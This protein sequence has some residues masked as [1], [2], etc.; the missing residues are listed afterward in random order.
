M[1]RKKRMLL[2]STA[3]RNP[4]TQTIYTVCPLSLDQ[5]MKPPLPVSPLHVPDELKLLEGDVK[6]LVLELGGL[7]ILFKLFQP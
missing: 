3:N 6:V 7:F 2:Q 4:S 5:N 1:S